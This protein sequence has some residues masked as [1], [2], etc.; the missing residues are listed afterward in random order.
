MRRR[1]SRRLAGLVAI[2]AMA[3]ACSSAPADPYPFNP[4]PPHTAQLN[5]AAVGEATDA[6]VLFIRV[7]P[8]DTIDLLE[9]SATGDLDGANVRFQL[10]RPVQHA[11]GDHVIGEQMETLEGARVTAAVPTDSPDNT[12]GIVAELVAPAPGR[13]RVDS[14]RLKYRINGGPEQVGDG[15]DVVWTV[16]VDDPKPAD[17]PEEPSSD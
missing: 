16:C 7:R 12:V 1:G 3:A 4:P 17:C 14:I 5:P 2:A 6:V 15:T 8:G 13:Y 10:S 9:A 11:N